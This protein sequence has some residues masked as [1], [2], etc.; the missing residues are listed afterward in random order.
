MDAAGKLGAV[1]HYL[2]E[3]ATQRQLSPHTI[4]AYRRDLTELAALTGESGWDTVVHADIRRLA[5]KL[6]SQNL[7]PRSIARR[8]SCWRGF[9]GW[10]A[11][12]SKLAANPVDGVRA[13][14][15]ARLKKPSSLMSYSAS[16]LS[17]DSLPSFFSRLSR[18]N[19]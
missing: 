6:H 16:K 3:L 5:S 4:L 12:S 2:L 14:K 15:R 10:L 1:E 18:P 7:N 11:R 8:L 19:Q 17:V 9:F 13:P